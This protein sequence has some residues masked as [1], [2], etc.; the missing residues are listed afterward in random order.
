MKN[1]NP[2]CVLMREILEGML[3]AIRREHTVA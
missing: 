2:N 1:E 3:D